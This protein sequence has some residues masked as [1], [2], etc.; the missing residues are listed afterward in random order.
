MTPAPGSAMRRFAAQP[1]IFPDPAFA[2]TY[3]RQARANLARELASLQ[4]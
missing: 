2:R 3:D 1:L 4:A